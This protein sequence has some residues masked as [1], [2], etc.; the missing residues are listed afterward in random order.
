VATGESEESFQAAAGRAGRLPG[1]G[2][3]GHGLPGHGIAQAR[4][5]AYP[6][7]L[8]D[9]G[10]FGGPQSFA[11]QP[12]VPLTRQGGLLGTADTVIPDADYPNFN[13]FMV[14]FPDR[15]LVHAFE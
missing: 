10:T 9:P 8:V 11:N 13:P 15:Y 3:R 4:A 14:G 12:A 5:V 2:G 1:D 6:Y 7:R